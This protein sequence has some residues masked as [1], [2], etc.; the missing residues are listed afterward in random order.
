MRKIIIIGA[1]S[2]IGKAVAEIYISRGCKVGIAGRRE[3]ELQ[4]IQQQAPKQVE[5]EVIDITQEGAEKHLSRLIEKV[6]GMDLYFHSSGIGFQ[7]RT[8]EMSTEINTTQTNV[9]GFTRMVDTAFNY[10]KEK[11]KGHI[12]VISSVAGTK[13]IGVAPAYSATKRFQNTYIE[14]L[15]QLAHIDKLNISFT[16]I[17]P[18]FVATDLLKDA[19][20]PMLMKASSVAKKI[21]KAIQHKRKRIIIDR[22]YSALIFFWKLIPHCIWIRMSVKSSKK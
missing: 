13:G 3:K 12:A 2:G 8:L 18:G 16:D 19:N 22:R 5:Y 20:Y 7:N 15:T 14:A 4:S 11:G 1:T 9:V 21:V 10:F 6:G 17:K